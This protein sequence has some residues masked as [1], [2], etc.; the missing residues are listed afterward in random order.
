MAARPGTD[1]RANFM[2]NI[3]LGIVRFV[4]FSFLLALPD[5][6]SPV[7]ILAPMRNP[8]GS[9]TRDLHV[10]ECNVS[11]DN[12]TISLSRTGILVLD[13]GKV[14]LRTQLVGWGAGASKNG[15]EA[16]NFCE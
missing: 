2:E 3:L 14:Y 16:A 5:I 13:S 10:L 1:F 6:W 9:K 4:I 12:N 7:A 11:H 8:N 15:G